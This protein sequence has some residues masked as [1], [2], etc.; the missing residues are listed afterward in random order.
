MCSG[1]QGLYRTNPGMK[2]KVKLLALSEPPFTCRVSRN[3]D[4][5]LTIEKCLAIFREYQ[6]FS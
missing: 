3:Q 6:V 2:M 5:S 1:S 4:F